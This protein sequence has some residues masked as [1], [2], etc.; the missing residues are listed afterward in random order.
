M[1]TS[2]PASP[3]GWDNNP[4]LPFTWSPAASPANPSRKRARSKPRKTP[5]GSGPT[6][7]PSS[8]PS[9]PPGSSPK[10]SPDSSAEDSATSCETWT[11]SGLMR[12]G[13]VYPLPPSAPLTSATGSSASPVSGNHKAE[14]PTPTATPYGS[15]GNGSGNNTQSRG[16]PSLFSM[17]RRGL[18][19]TPT[20]TDGGPSLGRA[21]GP[22]LAGAIR[23]TWPTPTARD[24]KGPG[25]SGQLP[26]EMSGQPSPEFVE[27]L[28][29]FPTRWTDSD[30][31]ATPLFPRSPST[32]DDS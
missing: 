21:T 29:G 4:A 8:P 10:T 19:P 22:N 12:N 26:T 32:S 11:R 14:Y 6:W 1:P 28:M 20:S 2:E 15:S 16:R 18:W 25:Y 23:E 7:P 3:G 27:W 13:I 24:H 30:L 17:A 9:D 5:A 31:W